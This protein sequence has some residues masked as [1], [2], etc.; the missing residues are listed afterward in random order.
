MK[1]FTKALI[2]AATILALTGCASSGRKIEWNNARQLHNGQTPAEVTALMGK[3]YSVRS[4]GTD[5]QQ[6]VY[7]AVNVNLLTGTS[8]SSLSVQ[9]TCEITSKGQDNC[10]VSQVP[11]IPASFSN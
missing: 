3:P 9:F 8:S 6:W 1:I 11:S 2:L 5:K 4:L 7:V 10:L